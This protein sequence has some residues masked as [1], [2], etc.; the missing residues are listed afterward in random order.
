MRDPEE[1][2]VA[3]GA[4][5]V[6]ATLLVDLD[7]LGLILKV[8]AGSRAELDFFVDADEGAELRATVPDEECPV[9]VGNGAVVTTN[10]DLLHNNGRVA[11]SAYGD[12]VAA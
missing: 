7:E 2:V 6:D 10:A 3:F 5:T 8:E 12:I 1:K 9:P 4:A 11:V